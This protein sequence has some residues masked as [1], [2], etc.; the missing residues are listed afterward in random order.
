MVTVIA[1]GFDGGKRRPSVQREA[2]GVMEGAAS[3]RVSHERDFLQEL[4]RQREQGERRRV[5]PAVRDDDAAAV[6]T[7]P[8]VERTAG[9]TAAPPAP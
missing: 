2:T 1:T 4:E 3:T 8:R 6:V 9:E 7:S 5:Q